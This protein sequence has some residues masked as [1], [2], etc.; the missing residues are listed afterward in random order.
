MLDLKD[1][2]K[3][4]WYLYYC[5]DGIF[6]FPLD[7]AAELDK[8]VPGYRERYECRVIDSLAY[9]EAV[10][11]KIK[12]DFIGSG[13]PSQPLFSQTK[14]AVFLRHGDLFRLLCEWDYTN[15]RRGAT[16]LLFFS[17]DTLDAPK[18]NCI[19]SNTCMDAAFIGDELPD[20]EYMYRSQSTLTYALSLPAPVLPAGLGSLWRSWYSSRSVFGCSKKYYCDVYYGYRSKPDLLRPSALKHTK[21]KPDMLRYLLFHTLVM[22][23]F[24]IVRLQELGF[25]WNRHL[26]AWV[27][28]GGSVDEAGLEA[29]IAADNMATPETLGFVPEWYARRSVASGLEF[30]KSETSD[31]SA[32]WKQF[33]C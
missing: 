11:R 31:N 12:S 20:N 14:G 28:A 2:Y 17:R 5:S 16:P 4:L 21:E 18:L 33:A 22:R 6:L 7:P 25:A 3:R 19:V 30:E 1:I 32:L 27:G 8:F 26:S 15:R 23:K 29:F 24:D 13:D 9:S 10:P